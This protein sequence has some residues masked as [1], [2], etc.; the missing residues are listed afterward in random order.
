MTLTETEGPRSAPPITLLCGQ[1]FAVAAW[2]WKTFQ[3]HPMMIN[4]AFGLVEDGQLAGSCIFSDWNSVNVEFSYYGK[5]VLTANIIR[6]MARFALEGLGV[7]RVT[8]KIPRD[9]RR[10]GKL[11]L[12]Y[13]AKVEGVLW[14]FY[15]RTRASH[16]AAVQYVLF[17][18]E[19]MKIAGPRYR[20]SK[21]H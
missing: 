20:R 5:S 4:R 7:E 12:R 10:M 8:F 9:R 13:G 15:G 14:G 19:L 16:H 1:D 18:E 11:L 17:K 3:R 6:T 2:T 21:M